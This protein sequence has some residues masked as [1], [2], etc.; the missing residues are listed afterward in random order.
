MKTMFNVMYSAWTQRGSLPVN[1]AVWMIYSE[2]VYSVM[3]GQE[4]DKLEM[5]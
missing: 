2:W 4:M 3:G 5:I 1:T